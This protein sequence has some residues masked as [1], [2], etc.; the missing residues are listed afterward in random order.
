MYKKDDYE[1]LKRQLKTQERQLKS[2]F[3]DDLPDDV[4]KLLDDI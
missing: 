4:K 3:I 1:A 2:K